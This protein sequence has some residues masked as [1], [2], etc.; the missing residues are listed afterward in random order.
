MFH[1]LYDLTHECLLEISWSA[2][3]TATAL[4]ASLLRVPRQYPRMVGMLA[5]YA[6]H[7]ITPQYKECPGGNTNLEVSDSKIIR[8]GADIKFYFPLSPRRDCSTSSCWYRATKAKAW[9]EGGRGRVA[10]HSR[11]LLEI[12]LYSRGQSLGDFHNFRISSTTKS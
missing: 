11:S 12:I 4:C 6:E 2:L 5:I 1:Y 10:F 9:G 3:T 7:V 8:N